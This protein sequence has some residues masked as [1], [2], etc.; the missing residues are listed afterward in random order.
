L[1]GTDAP[2]YTMPGKRNIKMDTSTYGATLYCFKSE[3]QTPQYSMSIRPE[4]F[5]NESYLQPAKVKDPGPGAYEV[6]NY[7]PKH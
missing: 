2:K 3:I 6:E 4:S 7:K 5:L 1:I